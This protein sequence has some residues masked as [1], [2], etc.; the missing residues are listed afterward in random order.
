METTNF[1]TIEEIY[2][3][4]KEN[5]LNMDYYD[6]V[7]LHNEV[8]NNIS[9][10][11][12]MIFENDPYIIN[13]YFPD[14]FKALQAMFY[15]EYNPNHEFFTLNGYGNLESINDYNIMDHINIYEIIVDIYK[16]PYNYVD[17]VNFLTDEYIENIETL[18]EENK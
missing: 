8:C 17:Y 16:D 10:Y 9:H 13:D 2:S 5:I 6:I 4:I 3:D 12:N 18:K 11:D 7:T 14:S 1:K 15:G